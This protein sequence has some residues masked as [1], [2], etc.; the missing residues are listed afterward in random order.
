MATLATGSKFSTFFGATFTAV[1]KV[2]Q[3]WTDKKY[4]ESITGGIGLAFNVA[5][6]IMSQFGEASSSSNKNTTYTIIVKD[7]TQ[8]NETVT[9]TYQAILEIQNELQT[10]ASDLNSLQSQITA[11]FN[12]LSSDILTTD[13]VAAFGK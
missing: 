6:F 12:A 9:A 10:I 7:F 2:G 11:G 1:G 5:G 13:C 4:G 3:S 8:L